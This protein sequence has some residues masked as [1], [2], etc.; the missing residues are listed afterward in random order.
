MMKRNSN[1]ELLRIISILFIVISHYSVHNG[2]S[3]YDLPLGFNRF[4]LEISVLG[5]IGTIIFVIITGFFSINQEKP[6]KFKK[7]AILYF[8]VFFYSLTI[9]FIL[10][11]LG[12]EKFSMHMFITCLLPISFKNYWFVSVYILLY[13]FI[14]Y[15]NIMLNNLK[16]Y[17]H[18]RLIFIFI[19][20]FSVLRMILK[21]DY[22][23]NELMQ[24]IMFY[25]IGAYIGKY[26]DSFFL[27]KKC[28]IIGFLLS[29][30]IL[31][32]SV[33]LIDFASLKYTFFIGHSLILFNR[34]SIV[35][36]LFSIFLF[37]LFYNK[38][39]RNNNVIIS[40]ASCVFAVYLI[41]EHILIRKILWTDLLHISS[42][43]NSNIL[44]FHMFFSVLLIFI[45]CIIIEYFRKYAFEK[46]FIN[47]V[48][49]IINKIQ[50][51][52]VKLTKYMYSKIM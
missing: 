46:L 43:V 42:Y 2:I 19:L 36:I 31:V 14:P 18:L 5:N 39:E 41:S 48:F 13:I 40:I 22:Y 50:L 4:L 21:S 15:I 45:F 12:F 25:S 16:R 38:K 30:I 35:S 34:T 44:I 47:Y 23:G 24:F 32:S 26:R 52:I 3:N 27:K 51:A 17:E 9:Y 28:C 29:F 33:I 11:L 49:P 1:I 10:I 7:L 6:F 37:G 20:F 8:E